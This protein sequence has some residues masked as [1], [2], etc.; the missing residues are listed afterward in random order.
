MNPLIQMPFYTDRDSRIGFLA[1]LKA[2][3]KSTK[4]KGIVLV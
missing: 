4:K 3:D 1:G 2:A